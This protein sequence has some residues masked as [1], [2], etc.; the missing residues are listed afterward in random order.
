MAPSTNINQDI[1]VSDYGLNA[2]HSYG[3]TITE[4]I[5]GTSTMVS[6]R[7]NNV[8]IT[9][10]NGS[11]IHIDTNQGSSIKFMRY[12]LTITCEIVNYN[13]VKNLSNHFNNVFKRFF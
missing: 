12:I 5:N 6:S 13:T 4:N 11:T 3:F 8:R 2:L 1:Q 9:F 7:N 10:N